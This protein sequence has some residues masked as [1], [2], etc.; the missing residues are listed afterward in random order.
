MLLARALASQPRVLLADEPVAA[1]D[2]KHQLQTMKV[3]RNFASDNRACV[4]VLHDLSLAARYCDRLYLMHEGKMVAQGTAA[5]VLNHEN[6]KDVYGVEVEFGTGDT[7]MIVPL[8]E[9]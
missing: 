4:V 8:R 5:E 1:L 2:L 6:L 9:V 7:P 3:L